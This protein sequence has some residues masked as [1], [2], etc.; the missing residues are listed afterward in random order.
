MSKPPRGGGGRPRGTPSREAIAAFIRDNP[1]KA[2]KRDIARAFGLK[3]DA[4]VALKHVLRELEEEGLVEKRG[5]RLAA[6]GTLP[7]VMVLEVTGRDADG[8]LIARPAE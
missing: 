6:P 4:R 2:T 8:G 5:K 7:P 3:G 1:Q